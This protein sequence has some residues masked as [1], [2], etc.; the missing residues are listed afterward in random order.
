MEARALPR[1]SAV[2]ATELGASSTLGLPVHGVT[3]HPELEGIHKDP[4]THIQREL[5]RSRVLSSTTV[6]QHLLNSWKTLKRVLTPRLVQ[7]SCTLLH[8]C[9]LIS[10]DINCE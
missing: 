6:G 5:R 9:F 4:G 1:G 7:V 8:M 3:E 2:M 10:K